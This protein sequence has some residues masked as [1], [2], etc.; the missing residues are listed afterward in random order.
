MKI[1][2]HKK[3]R[4]KRVRTKISGTSER[5]RLSVTVSNKHIICQIIDDSKSQTLVYSSTV[6]NKDLSKLP[7]SEKAQS[8]GIDIAKKAKKAKINQVVFD[9]NGRLYHGR[10]KILADEARANGLKF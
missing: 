10:I 9:R 4:K 7:L 3:S 5:P 2:D 1:L 6:G 8:V